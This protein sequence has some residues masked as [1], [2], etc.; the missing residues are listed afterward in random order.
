M[1]W[2]SLQAV[3]DQMRNLIVL[4]LLSGSAQA[5]TLHVAG[6]S[7]QAAIDKASPGDTIV[8]HAGIY[9][10]SIKVNRDGLTLV[11]APGEEVVITGAD[12][13][14][15]SDWEKLPDKPIL[16][17]TPWKY[18]WP[19]HP[20]DERHKLIGRGEQVIADGH[21]LRQVADLD[22]MESGTFYAD[23][24]NALYV[25]L[26]EGAQ[27][28]KAS[29]RRVLMS[30]TA[31]HVVV[32]G[33]HFRYASNAAQ[34]AAFDVAGS[35]NLAE[36]CLVEWTNG[37]GAGLSGER[38][39]MRRLVSRFNGQMGMSG[40]GSN[41]MEECTLEGNNVKGY[42]KGWEAGGIKITESRGFRI[43]RC[44]AIRNDGPGFWFDIDNRNE[45]V[46]NSYAAENNGSGIFVEISETATIRQNVCVR[47]G[48]KDEPGAWNG[49]GI[50]LGEAM[51]CTVEHNISVGNRSGIVV[52]QQKVR[53]LPAD[54]RHDRA[55]E[56]QY[57]SDGH[58]FSR[59]IL[60][61][62]KDW[63]FAL[64]GDNPFFG[65]KREAT[66]AEMELWDPDKRG[67]QSGDNIY[68]AA[69][70][71]GLILWGAK[72]LPRHQEFSDLAKF[73]AGHKL[74]AT[75]IVADPQFKNWEGGDFTMPPDSPAAK[76]VSRK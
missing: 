14:P 61:F 4:L 2:D 45:L 7:I 67:W 62:N 68:F 20:N 33:L 50:E 76:I 36:D 22:H 19:T 11:A 48:L 65:A 49:G 70:G 46:E 44:R 64:Y 73:T 13:I 25:W 27:Q 26:P 53:T 60:A 63:Q 34:Q 29:V 47:N 56:K 35:D 42:S 55:A 21:L 72:W 24:G 54:D 18:R 1:L 30:V 40:H 59:N 41:L 5:A 8:L 12:P 39:T 43:V 16:R 51:H 23:P 31:S 38:N 17:H 6:T 3:Q 57:Y 75:S 52:R 74:D 10:E 71:E 9:R 66:A 69:P 32:R 15:L 28:V 37:V 58:V